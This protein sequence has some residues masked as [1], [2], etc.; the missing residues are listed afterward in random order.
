[1][2][3]AGCLRSLG[4]LFDGPCAGLLFTGSKEAHK[5]EEIIAGLDK[6]IKS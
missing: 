2:Y 5:A 3:L 6:L 4:T 1:M